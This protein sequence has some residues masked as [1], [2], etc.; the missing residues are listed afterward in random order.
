MEGQ[1]RTTIPGK[2]RRVANNEM[3]IARWIPQ[4]QRLLGDNRLGESDK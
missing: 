2:R 1:V 4:G 3:R